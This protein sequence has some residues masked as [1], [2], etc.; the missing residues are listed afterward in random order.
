MDKV[1][2]VAGIVVVSIILGV[3]FSKVP[4]TE[5]YMNGAGKLSPVTEQQYSAEYLYKNRPTAAP[6][7]A[8]PSAAAPADTAKAA[9]AN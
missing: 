3:Y 4:I 2:L 9:P 6:A 5:A 7:A 8:T 1:S